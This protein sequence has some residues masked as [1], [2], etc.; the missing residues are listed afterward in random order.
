MKTALFICIDFLSGRVYSEKA[1]NTNIQYV[2]TL[3]VALELKNNLFI[4]ARTFLHN[5]ISA[6]FHMHNR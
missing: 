2:T 3:S 6:E 5:K 1:Q 4:E